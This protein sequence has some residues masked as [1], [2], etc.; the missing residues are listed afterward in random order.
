[1]LDAKKI[2]ARF[3]DKDTVPMDF[4]RAYTMD[5]GEQRVDTIRIKDITSY[6][7]DTD[8]EQQRTWLAKELPEE[9]MGKV[10]VMSMCENEEF[11]EDVG[12]KVSENMFY[13]YAEDVTT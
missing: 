5:Y 12:Y 7:F 13:L 11:V 10:A 8:T 3:Q 2:F 1:M 6:R 4:V 9:L